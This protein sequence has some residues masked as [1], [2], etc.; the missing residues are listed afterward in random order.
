MMS[1]YLIFEFDVA[2]WEAYRSYSAQAGPLLVRAGAEIVAMSDN[3]TVF[4]GSKPGVSAIVR[5]DS[6]GQ[7]SAFYHGDEYAPLRKLRLD[8]TRDHSCIAIPGFV[9]PAPP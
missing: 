5:F 3:A 9:M 7:A 2:D 8:A 4:E 1:A 6:M